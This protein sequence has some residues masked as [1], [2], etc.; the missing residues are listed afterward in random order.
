MALSQGRRSQLDGIVLSLAE[1]GASQSEVQAVVGDFTSKFSDSDK[2][3]TDR[4]AIE[5]VGGFLGLEAF[6]KGIG[7]A[8]RQLTGQNVALEEKAAEEAQ[9]LASLP[10]ETI[11]R[12]QREGKLDAIRQGSGLAQGLSDIT[13]ERLT[14]RQI[15]GS[16]ASTALLATGG[17][18]GRG[19]T[20]GRLT[21]AIGGIQ[22]GVA[23][24][25]PQATSGLGRFAAGA[26]PTVAAGAVEGAGFAGAN[27]A[28][29][30]GT[31]E[32]IVG[33]VKTGAV[34]GGAIPL[35]VA[36]AKPIL[37][38]TGS[39]IAD[40]FGQTTGAG[41]EAVRRGFAGSEGF[42]AGLRGGVSGEDILID[43]K[44]GLRAIRQAR[45]NQYRK[46]LAKIAAQTDEISLDS[47]NEKLPEILKGF[48]VTTSDDGFNFARSSIG[49]KSD[50]AILRDVLDDVKNWDDLSPLGVDTLK[51]RVSDVIDQLEPTS[52][53]GALLSQ[54]NDQIIKT[55]N[56][57]VP[58]YTRLTSDYAIVTEQIRDLT[59]TLSLKDSISKETAVKKLLT[60]LKENNEFRA[61]LVQQ[62]EQSGGKQ[63]LDRIAGIALSTGLPRGL[64]AKQVGGV[65]LTAILGG[66]I[67]NPKILFTL[68]TLLSFSPRVVGEAS[69]FSGIAQRGVSAVATPVVRR[70]TPALIG[71]GIGESTKP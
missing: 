52:K 69:R 49:S 44:K 41:G 35:A 51:Q 30:G 64:A 68:A 25:L 28:A 63:L 48:G 45:G 6:G 58:G 46:G 39:F 53:S 8:A 54:V 22:Q 32:E 10:R 27:V 47:V 43:A 17:T 18:L 61:Q 62:L 66:G 67:I 60:V 36:A 50:T 24:A 14:N 1:Q 57:Q 34:V 38:K 11:Q 15:I 31:T 19:V 70:A 9:T 33:A 26:T 3:V 4:S 65:A 37:R 42:K 71:G 5:K 59:K 7:L 56:K 13:T 55:L 20:A 29:Q 2:Q 12:L 16:A 23:R 21:P 40:M